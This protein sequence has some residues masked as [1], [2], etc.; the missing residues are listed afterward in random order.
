MKIK[1]NSNTINIYI[2]QNIIKE[3]FFIDFI[4]ENIK[5]ILFLNN[6]VLIFTNSIESSKREY[7][8]KTIINNY[9]KDNDVLKSFLNKSINKYKHKPIKIIFK[10]KL[11]KEKID[12]HVYAYDNKRLLIYMKKDNEIIIQ[13]FK[14]RLFIYTEEGTKNSIT[15]NIEDFKTKEKLDKIL[16]K[17]ELLNYIFNFIYDNKFLSRMYSNLNLNFFG[18]LNKNY[19]NENNIEYYKILECPLEASKTDLKKSY[20]KL[21]KIFHPDLIQNKEDY[22]IEFHKNK[23]QKIQEA[24]EQLVKK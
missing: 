11:I 18:N 17:K 8:L 1:I 9:S 14:S 21:V 13:Y 6:E 15:I 16:E 3:N 20:K 22:I 2:T 24:Y 12:I 23:F 7:L 5:N 4:K 10:N 19:L